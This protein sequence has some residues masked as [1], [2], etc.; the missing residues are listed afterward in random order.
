LLIITPNYLHILDGFQVQGEGTKRRI[1]WT[2]IVS[3]R[4]LS[5]DSK[6]RPQSLEPPP[7]SRKLPLRKKSF[8]GTKLDWRAGTEEENSWLS[9]IWYQM[10]HADFGYHRMPLDQVSLSLSRTEV[11]DHDS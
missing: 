7:S 2:E 4:P 3:Q 6:R 9:D 8:T 10:L 1:T 5:P 11:L